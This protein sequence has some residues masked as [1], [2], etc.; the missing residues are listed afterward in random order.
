MDV[1]PYLTF[2]GNCEAACEFYAE[3]FGGDIT[4]LQRVRNSPVADQLP[5]EVQDKV[6]HASVG[7]GPRDIYASDALMGPYEPPRGIRISVSF[8]DR[9]RA[10]RI[11]KRLA[12]DGTTVMP[13]E[14]TFWA[15]GFG[16]CTD[17]FGT[18]WMISC[19]VAD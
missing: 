18:P 12:K 2:D 14:R 6:L 3:V 17:R 8:P 5:P 4:A 19:D 15:E 16:M 11:F 10:I 13:F 9:D 1:T 7:I